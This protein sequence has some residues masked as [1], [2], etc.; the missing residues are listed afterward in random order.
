MRGLVSALAAMVVLA[1]MLA[2]AGGAERAAAGHQGK[3]CG[4]VTDGPR[5]YRVR[6]QNLDCAKARRGAKRYLRTRDALD[7]FACD[8]P[9]GRIQFFCKS[10]TRV[11]WAVR[12]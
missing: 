9:A 7:G 8:R 6:S 12:L 10:G 2:G 5:D 4:I 1:A 3:N 11:Y